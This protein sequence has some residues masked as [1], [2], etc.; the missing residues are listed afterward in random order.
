[1]SDLTERDASCSNLSDGGMFVVLPPTY[2]ARYRNLEP[3]TAARPI[4]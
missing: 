4:L 1:M 3:V 2:G